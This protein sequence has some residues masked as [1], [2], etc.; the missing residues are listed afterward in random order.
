MANNAVGNERVSAVVG[1]QLTG[2]DFSTSSPNLPQRIAIIAE[3]NDANQSG[4][5]TNGVVVTSAQ[6]AGLQFGFGSPIHLAMRILRPEGGGGI[7]GI[8]TIVY[9]QTAAAGATAKVLTITPTGT[10]TGNGTH[11]IVI[12]GRRSIDGFSYDININ[13]GDTAPQIT[14]KIEDAVNAALSSPV[15]ADGTA[16]ETNLTTKWSGLTAQDL[17]VTV[18]T[19][20]N[21]LDLTYTVTQTAAGAGTP[22]I[23]LALNKFANNWN[24]AVINGY[25]LHSGT[26]T[27]LQN[28]NGRPSATTPTG[29][30][31][32]IIMKPLVAFSGSCLENPST[33]T[34]PLK[35]DVTIAV[36][37]APL[38]PG[39]P[40]E[41][42]A[43]MA[44]VSVRI[45]QDDPSLDAY[46]SYY[47]DMPV[48][49]TGYIGAMSFYEYRD[50]FVKKGC[51]TVDFINN[52]YKIID[53]VTTY[54]PVGEN[55]AALQFSYVRNLFLDF[56]VYFGWHL[57]EQ[58]HIVGHV[59]AND[60]DTVASTKVVKPKIVKGLISKYAEDLA[61]RGLIV[62]APFM[63]AGATVAISTSNPNRIDVSYPYKR[64]G[65]GRIVSTVARAGFNFGTLTV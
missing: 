1:Y 14:Q 4:L 51:S 19:N 41:A 22:N 57:I 47:P 45:A 44:V 58:T 20:G 28:Y 48:P 12:A 35:D 10:A 52:Q 59:I 37:P 63:Q 32:P 43:N 21:D 25:G 23:S 56:N 16:Y 42:A 7:G 55:P 38:S 24:T 33:I 26:I 15:I 9:A 53:L 29:R 2:E 54:H 40:F 3:A 13:E 5:D 27:L 18:D 17:T 62:D 61:L 50:Q 36:A 30:Y 11:T 34:D 64:S 39:F 49:A 31:N 65:V 8:P 46:N 60:N 6:S